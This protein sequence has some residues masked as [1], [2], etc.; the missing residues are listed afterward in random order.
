M[1]RH[2]RLE[3]TSTP[4]GIIFIAAA[5]TMCGCQSSTT[6]NQRGVRQFQQGDYQS[7]LDTFQNAL[8]NNPNDPDAYYNLA[9][10]L[11]DWGRRGRDTNLMDQAES[12]YHRCLDLNG[13]HVECYRALAVLLVDTDRRDS[14]FTLLERWA[15]R[16]PSMAA[17]LVEL[18]RLNEE[19]GKDD[20]AR[21]LLAQALDS[22]SSDSRAWAALGRL[23]ENEGRYAQALTDYQH[24]Y[25]LN[26]SNPGIPNQIASLQQ[27]L[28]RAPQTGTAGRL[29]RLGSPTN[30]AAGLSRSGVSGGSNSDRQRVTRSSSNWIAR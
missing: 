27:R 2:R 5:V 24:A 8:S 17:P 6:Y 22:D 15:Q 9:A 3:R 13:N 29:A 25:N 26:R 19:F 12:L 4:L 23:R 16:S 14:A 20:S 11:H 18:A 7:A 1:F 28:A 21:Q 10:T 30:P